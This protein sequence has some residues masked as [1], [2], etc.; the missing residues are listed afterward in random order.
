MKSEETKTILKIKEIKADHLDSLLYVHFNSFATDYINRSIYASPL[1]KNYLRY[2]FEISNSLQN[3]CLLGAWLKNTLLGY[4]HFKK[5][6]Q[7]WHLNYI[8]ILPD[9]Q[10]RGIGRL[11]WNAGIDVG[12]ARGLSEISLDVEENNYFALNWYMRQG[13]SATNSKWLYTKKLAFSKNDICD[14]SILNWPEA[15]SM[16]NSFG[17]SKFM[18]LIAGKKYEIGRMGNFFN[19]SFFPDDKTE[20]VLYQIEGGREL[21]INSEIQTNSSRY[22]FIC[23]NLR[24]TGKL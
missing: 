15:E 3:D 6:D 19:L 24:L 1:V 4:I 7:Y 16:Q 5:L 20:N 12:K 21:L 11:L 13:L 18:L 22:L 8:A 14:F 9:Y 17:F 10:S 2:L 23:R